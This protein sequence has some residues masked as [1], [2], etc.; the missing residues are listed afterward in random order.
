M[1]RPLGL[2]KCGTRRLQN[3]VNA[4]IHH[5]T[6]AGSFSTGVDST[7]VAIGRCCFNEALFGFLSFRP[8]LLFPEIRCYFFPGAMNPIG[9]FGGSS[10]G[11]I[12]ASECRR[13]L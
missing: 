1:R 5:L 13:R 12:S 11:S 4:G 9:R 10:G 6:G 3:G 2:V 8:P 7:I